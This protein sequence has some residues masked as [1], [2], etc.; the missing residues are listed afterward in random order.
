MDYVWVAIGSALG[1]VGRYTAAMAVA[2]LT[3]AQFPWG[4]I[5]INI[6]GSF[7]IGLVAT[8]TAAGARF[9]APPGLRLFIMV[10]FCGG[11]TTFSSFS[12]QTLELLRDGHNGEAL[13]NIALSVVLCMAGVAAGYHAGLV[14]AAG[15]A[16]VQ[17]G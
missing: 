10:G 5:L 11:F 6:V 13:G 8:M 7:I 4:T 15:Q 12:L 1:G 2:R 16:I 14:L 17:Q 3:G 9:A